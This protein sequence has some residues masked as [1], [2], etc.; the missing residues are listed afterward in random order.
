M[1]MYTMQLKLDF[2]VFSGFQVSWSVCDTCAA[3]WYDDDCFTKCG[4][5]IVFPSKLL[6]QHSAYTDLM[7]HELFYVL[8]ICVCVCVGGVS[9][10][11]FKSRV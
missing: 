2:M 6:L 10:S 8:S 3:A 1:Q 11:L 4:E 7:K 5:M 9:F